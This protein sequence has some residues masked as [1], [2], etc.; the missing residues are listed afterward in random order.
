MAASDHLSAT[1]AGQLTSADFERLAE[2]SYPGYSVRAFGPDA[3]S[4]PTDS[5]MVSHSEHNAPV[6][7]HSSVTGQ[8]IK[9]FVTSRKEPLSRP[10]M[11]AG[12]WTETEEDAEG[13]KKPTDTYL[14][15]SEA[16]PRTHAGRK[17]AI[18]RGVS[19]GEKA[20]GVINEH[21]DYVNEIDLVN[22]N[23]LKEWA[24]TFLET[25]ESVIEHFKQV[26]EGKRMG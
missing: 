23:P 15:V 19:T 26:H 3:G 20:I 21:G 10:N 6:M 22:R 17:A 13:N 2:R 9:D 14:D 7:P 24:S 8:T 16:M 4:A 25:P 5:Y 1:Q 12:A 11:Y 18:A